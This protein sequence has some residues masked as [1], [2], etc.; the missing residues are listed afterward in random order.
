MII[1]DLFSG[2]G[3][4][5]EGFVREGFEIVAHVEKEKWA[6]ETLK[7]RICYH[8]LKSRNDLELYYEYVKCSQNYKNIE[9]DRKIIYDKYPELKDKVESEVLNKTFGDP[10]EDSKAT[11]KDEIIKLIEK[12]LG[13]RKVNVI[14]GGPPC[15][16]YS[17]IGRGR[18]GKAAREDKRN[19]LFYYYRDIVKHF[20]PEVFIFENVPG[21]LSAHNGRIFDEIKEEF[22]GIG[23]NLHSGKDEKNPRNNIVDASNLGVYQKRKRVIL[24]GTRINLSYPDFEK[25]AIKFDEAK[26]TRHAIGDLPPLQPGE[27]NDYYCEGYGGFDRSSLSQFQRLMR[28]D[29]SIGGILHHMARKHLERDRRNYHRA[30]EKA[31][32]G[33][34][35]KYMDIPNGDSTHKNK[36]DFEDRYRVH[37]WEDTPHTIVAHIAKDGHYNI[38]PD[39][40]QLRSLTV[41]EAARI[42]SFPDSYKF[43]GPRTWQ[44]VQIGNAVPPLMS[45]AIARA[46]KEECFRNPKYRDKE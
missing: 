22:G 6:C 2:A 16:A 39:E 32:V 44:Y 21:I 26:S 28:E 10:K 27:G 19:F 15:Q 38:H 25:Y 34:Q 30:I 33:E 37:W 8:Y 9:L 18:M 46:V 42:Q 40:S 14:I 24:F 31:A 11:S 3:G 41:R 12:K 4:L 13:G 29:E 23:Y 43:E 20:K 45:Q 1:V 5:T 17:L 7:T 35:L 36:K